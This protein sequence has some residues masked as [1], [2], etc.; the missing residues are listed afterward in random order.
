[1]QL[2]IKSCTLLLEPAHGSLANVAVPGTAGHPLR[3]CFHAM[4]GQRFTHY[5]EG[6]FTVVA[7][8]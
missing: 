3:S 2:P 8:S 7:N 4:M 1:M 5:R 6:G